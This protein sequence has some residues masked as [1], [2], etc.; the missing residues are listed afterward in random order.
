LLSHEAGGDWRSLKLNG[1]L[2]GAANLLESGSIAFHRWV[3]GQSGPHLTKDIGRMRIWRLNQSIVNPLAFATRRNHPGT[4]QVSKMSRNLRLIYLQNFDEKTHA[5]LVVSDEIN[6]PQTSLIRECLKQKFDA[7]FVVAHDDLFTCFGGLTI[8]IL[9]A[10]EFLFY[11]LI[12][13]QKGPISIRILRF[14]L[15]NAN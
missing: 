14:K 13:V 9:S 5:N 7:I 12:Y 2:R 8:T 1:K 15:V 11:R 10:P 3:V 4:T 6:Q